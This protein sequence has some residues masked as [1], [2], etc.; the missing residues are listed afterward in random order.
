[1]P[2]YE[3]QC[4][5]CG[6]DFEVKQSFADPPLEVCEHC[7]GRLRKLFRPPAIRFVGSGYYVNDSRSKKPG[8]SDGSAAPK[9]SKDSKDSKDSKESKGADAK[10]KAP[11][12]TSKSTSTSTDS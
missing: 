3:Y 9:E 8:G 6:V 11:A 5:D 7:G 4:R 10:A 12:E 1:M 2:T